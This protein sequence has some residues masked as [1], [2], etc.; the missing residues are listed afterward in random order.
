M[1]DKSLDRV[2][3]S[4]RRCAG[5]EAGNPLLGEGSRRIVPSSAAPSGNPAGGGGPMVISEQRASI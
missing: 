5:A 3:D 4:G 2:R 1:Q